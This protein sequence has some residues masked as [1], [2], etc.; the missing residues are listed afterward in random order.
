MQPILNCLTGTSLI[1]TQFLT[2]IG[3]DKVSRLFHLNQTK[4]LNTTLRTTYFNEKM[5][6]AVICDNSTESQQ[7]VLRDGSY[8]CTLKDKCL[9]VKS[10]VKMPYN[11]LTIM[12]YNDALKF[13]QQWAIDKTKKTII[14]F[15]TGWRLSCLGAI[16]DD[17]VD[18]V[19]KDTKIG[20]DQLWSFEPVLINGV[21][22]CANY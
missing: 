14:H 3:C 6:T 21:F 8:I 9:G 20:R 10:F 11:I 18:V 17:Q 16:D 4:C 19:H 2:E 1:T 22:K 15:Q 12:S 13:K 7:W 5:L